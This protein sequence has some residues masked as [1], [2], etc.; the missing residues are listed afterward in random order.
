MNLYGYIVVLIATYSAVLL[1]ADVDAAEDHYKTLGVKKKASDKEIKRA[2]RKL[3]LKYHPDKNKEKDAEEKFLKIGKAYEILSDPEKR[4]KYD[5]YG[6]D[7]TGP[8]G[9]NAGGFQHAGGFQNADFNQ[10]FK[11]FDEAMNSH[12]KGHHYKHHGNGGF[13]HFN[14][15][16]DSGSFFDFDSLFH[17]GDE[18]ELFGSFQGNRRSQGGFG[19]HFGFNGG[20]FGHMFD[21][22][23]DGGN[24]YDR[25]HNSG[26]HHHFGNHHAHDNLHHNMHH[27]MHHHQFSQQRQQR[28]QKVTQR[29]G[30]QVITFTQCS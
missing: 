9:S 24:K 2:F 22:F 25:A 5:M 30:N 29:V 23:F 11:Q 15:F 18:D 16:G 28:C 10:F 6:D 19:N 4:K 17:D 21:D 3:A 8:E 12:R 27:N 20:N 1:Y 26:H 13:R 7:G 14:T